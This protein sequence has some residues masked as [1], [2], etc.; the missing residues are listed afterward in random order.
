MSLAYAYKLYTAGRSHGMGAI[1]LWEW[2]KDE[3]EEVN[4]EDPD[5]FVFNGPLSLSINHL[6]GLSFE[7]FLKAAYVA[8]GG[9]PSDKHL[10]D[11]IGH[12]IERALEKA[13][14]QGFETDAPHLHGIVHHL[15]EPY[16]K[17]Y[18]RYQWPDGYPLPEFKQVADALTALE[19]DV[20]TLCMPDGVNPAPDD[21]PPGAPP[22]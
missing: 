19:A 22:A 14:A 2:A 9:A 5:L 12:N 4:P 6:A 13:E 7:L 15:S 3:A 17:H 10:R 1:R 21:A 18:F 11:T 8:K 20:K 16:A